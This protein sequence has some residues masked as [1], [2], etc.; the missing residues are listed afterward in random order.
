MNTKFFLTAAFCFL[1]TIIN[2]QTTWTDTRPGGAT[3]FHNFNMYSFN[4]ALSGQ[5]TNFNNTENTKG[6]RYLF[7]N[8]VKGNVIN[9]Q[10]AT[11]VNDSFFYNLDKVQN[12][13]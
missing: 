7:D 2:C 9:A 6:K 13:L 3:S 8:W 1:V 12:D 4:N 10:G 5:F 11:V